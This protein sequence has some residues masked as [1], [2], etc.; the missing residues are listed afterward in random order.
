MSNG[1]RNTTEELSVLVAEI[2]A[3]AYARGQADARKELL[4]LLGAE[5]AP[6]AGAKATR[7]RG[8]KKAAA[9]NPRASGRKRAP[10]GSVLRFVE[11]AL[12]ARPGLTPPEIMASAATDMERLIKLSSV[13]TELRNGGQQGKYEVSAGRWSLS[14]SASGVSGAS[15]AGASGTPAGSESDQGEAQGVPIGSATMLGTASPESE[16]GESEDKGRLGLTW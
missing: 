5:G 7:G 11:Q 14:E 2:E 8:A 16:A 10:K 4:E 9:P 1:S 12:R 13:R 15:E 6:V 3:A